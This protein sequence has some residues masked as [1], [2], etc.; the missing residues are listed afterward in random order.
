MYINI[1]INYYCQCLLQISS[2]YPNANKFFIIIFFEWNQFI[3]IIEYAKVK[4]SQWRIWT[5]TTKKKQN[6]EYITTT[7]KTIYFFVWRKINVNGW[8]IKHNQKLFNQQVFFNDLL[9]VCLVLLLLFCFSEFP[10]SLYLKL[11][12]FIHRFF[13]CESFQSTMIK[14]Q[15]CESS[16]STIIDLNEFFQQPNKKKQQQS[17]KKSN[18]SSIRNEEIIFECWSILYLICVWLIFFLL[19]PLFVCL[20][21]ICHVSWFWHEKRSSLSL[22]QVWMKWEK[23]EENNNIRKK[24][25][26]NNSINESMIDSKAQWN[27]QI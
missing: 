11:M 17:I 25:K 14:H 16:I 19:F 6:C 21:S 10:S 12:K 8:F 22:S 15:N 4:L 2:Y 7:L 5:T 3:I 23:K 9:N 27:T 13:C 1:N 20:P 26:I 24:K 18:V